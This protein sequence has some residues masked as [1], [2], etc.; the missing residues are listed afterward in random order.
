MSSS[1]SS[2]ASVE[3]TQSRGHILVPQK[4]L[5]TP[6]LIRAQSVPPAPFEVQIPL[7][8]VL[9]NLAEDIAVARLSLVGILLDQARCQVEVQVYSMHSS[10]GLY[11]QTEDH[12]VPAR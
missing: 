2:I 10:A 8:M 3:G 12:T 4:L 1:T 9:T 11:L 5:E 7:E 6:R